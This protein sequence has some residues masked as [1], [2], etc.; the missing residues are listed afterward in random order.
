VYRILA[1]N[2]LGAGIHPMKTFGIVFNH[3][4]QECSVYPK[5]EGGIICM[6]SLDFY[7]EKGVRIELSIINAADK[8]AAIR[9]AELINQKFHYHRVE[10]TLGRYVL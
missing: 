1:G 2:K 8:D 5:L 4:E 6:R 10:D 9:E 3:D 7:Q